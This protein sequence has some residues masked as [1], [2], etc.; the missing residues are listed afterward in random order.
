MMPTALKKQLIPELEGGFV[1]KRALFDKCLE[2]YPIAQWDLLMQKINK[3]N[4][5]NKKNNDFI[6]R[7][8]AGVKIVEVDTTGRL[9]V[10]KE[11]VNFANLE[12]D[13][14]L[15]AVGEFVEIWDKESYEK[16]ITAEDD[17][18]FGNMAQDIMGDT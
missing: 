4:R 14:A 13:I 7:F 12:K 10:P 5:F 8:L 1:V 16:T 6:R 2:L 18:K 9:L 11:L 15:S 3:L 17:E